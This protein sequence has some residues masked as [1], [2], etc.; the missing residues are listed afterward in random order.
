MKDKNLINRDNIYLL[1]ILYISLL[2]GFYFGENLNFGAKPDW[3]NGNFPVIRD[4]SENFNK[5]FYNYDLYN[6]RHSPVYLIFLS[7]FSKIGFN[8]I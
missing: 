4:F 8:F 3:Y 6:H 1:L 5:T 7:F 2:I